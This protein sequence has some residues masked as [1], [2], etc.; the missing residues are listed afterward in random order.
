[1]RARSLKYCISLKIAILFKQTVQTLMKLDIILQIQWLSG[2]E[3]L[4]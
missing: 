4:T 3:S 2:I 1:M